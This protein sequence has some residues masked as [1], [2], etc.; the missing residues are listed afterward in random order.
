L[1]SPFQP[2]SASYSA[3][4]L[5]SEGIRQSLRLFPLWREIIG[6]SLINMLGRHAPWRSMLA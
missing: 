4:W 5:S 2:L 1:E 3:V 6:K